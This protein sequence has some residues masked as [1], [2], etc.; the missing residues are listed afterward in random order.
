MLNFWLCGILC[1][2]VGGRFNDRV[3]RFEF[4]GGRLDI[5]NYLDGFGD[6]HFF[7]DRLNRD[8]LR[9]GDFFDFINLCR[10]RDGFCFDHGIIGRGVGFNWYL[11]NCHCICDRLFNQCLFRLLGC[12]EFGFGGC[13]SGC[14]SA[15]FSC[16]L[17]AFLQL[18]L[19][20][21]ITLDV[22]LPACEASCEPGV[23]A[24]APDG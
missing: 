21:D 10:Y 15:L 7:S 18:N 19:V 20:F 11:F 23:L 24:F 13:E 4:C 6:F 3:H 16:D 17:G 14:C 5:C 22:H 8:R 9:N 1:N 12:G 2:L